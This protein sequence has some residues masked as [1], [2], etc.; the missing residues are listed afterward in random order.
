MTP[1][2][3][4]VIFL[5]LDM[6]KFT[7]KTSRDSC[8]CVCTF[9]IGTKSNFSKWEVAASSIESVATMWRL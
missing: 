3:I 8:V 9:A 6:S 7:D 4:L 5:R 1:R 2:C